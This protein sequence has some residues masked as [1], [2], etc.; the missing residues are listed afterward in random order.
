MKHHLAT[1]V[2]NLL[3]VFFLVSLI[4]APIYFAKN[5]AQVAG[6]KS[7]SPYLLVSQTEK[8]PSMTFSQS[9]NTYTITLTKQVP[10]QAYLS[11]IIVNNPTSETKTYTIK[12]QSTENKLFFGENLNNQLIKINIPSQSSTPISLL[13]QSATDAQS[14]TF[15]IQTN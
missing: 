14:V 15:Q 7:E 3:A 10:S 6:V 12:N 13:S 2:Y 1:I 5:F 4:A 11:I 9:Q 8:F